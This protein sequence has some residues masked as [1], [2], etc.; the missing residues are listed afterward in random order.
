MMDNMISLS[1][2]SNLLSEAISLFDVHR[3]TFDVEMV[4]VSK[5]RARS[6]IKGKHSTRFGVI[7]RGQG[8]RVSRAQLKC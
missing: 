7:I 1:S 3:W 8:A 4:Q 6:A 5:F 2:N